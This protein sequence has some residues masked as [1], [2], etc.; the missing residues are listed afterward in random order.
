[1]FPDEFKTAKMY[2]YFNE[3]K[4]YII[5]RN[6]RPTPLLPTIAKVIEK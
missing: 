4:L 5:K 2:S 3:I 1:M 6:Y